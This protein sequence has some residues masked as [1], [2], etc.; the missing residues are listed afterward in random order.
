MGNSAKT[1]NFLK[2][3]KKYANAQKRQMI[4]EV[5]QLESQKT[6]LTKKQ[7]EQD[8]AKLIEQRLDKKRAEQTR[9]LANRTREGQRE[10][11]LE[12]AEMTEKIFALARQ[13]LSDYAKTPEYREK[14]LKSSA[15]LAELF[16][17]KPCVLY[18]NERDL[19]LGD[20]ILPLFTEESELKADPQIEI[21]GIKGY[22]REKSIVAD[23]TLDSS[24]REQREWFTQNAELSVL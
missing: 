14:L 9:I 16:E 6:E 2:A 7:A 5:E 21:G 23:E 1:D 8:S 17:G 20:K 3:I 4:S 12:R 24:L 19:S 18:V 22:C 13:K 11:F 15:E 10:L